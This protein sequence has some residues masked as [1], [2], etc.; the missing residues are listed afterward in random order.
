MKV[1]IFEEVKCAVLDKIHIISF[2]KT[3]QNNPSA[4]YLNLN[5]IE[6]KDKM[7]QIL[8]YFVDAFHLLNYNAFFPYPFFIITQHIETYPEICLAKNE[9]SLPKH[10]NHQISKLNSNELK[11]LNKV[12]LLATKLQHLYY[13]RS[14]R[15]VELLSFEQKRLYLNTHLCNYYEEMLDQLRQYALTE[16]KNKNEQQKK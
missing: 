14:L 6:T 8:E 10:F 3:I 11:L 4:L 1:P 12:N 7:A 16:D 5:H 13:N 2:I 15:S 9:S